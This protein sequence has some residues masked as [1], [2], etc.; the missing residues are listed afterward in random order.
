MPPVAD[1]HDALA[2]IVGGGLAQFA[3]A[4]GFDQRWLQP[5]GIVSITGVRAEMPWSCMYLLIFMPKN[6]VVRNSPTCPYQS[7]HA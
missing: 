4:S 2:A 5:L 3:L 6:L 7:G 1:L